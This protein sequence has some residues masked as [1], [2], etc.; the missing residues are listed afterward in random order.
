[1]KKI[2]CMLL[3]V[4]MITTLFT[5]LPVTASAA[6]AGESVARP[7]EPEMPGGEFG[8]CSWEFNILSGELTVS[9]TGSTGDFSGGAAKPWADYVNDIESVVVMNGITELGRATF[10]N[11]P[12]LKTA[13]IAPSVKTI[14][15][16]VFYK[17]KKLESVTLPDTI[18]S[19][20][21]AAFLSTGL[22]A[23]TI[24]N[25]NCTLDLYSVGFSEG[26]NMQINPKS[27]F[28]I[29]GYKGSKAYTYSLQNGFEFVDLSAEEH[30]VDVEQGT[31]YNAV[32]NQ[33][34]TTAHAG[35]R[36]YCAHDRMQS[37]KI[38]RRFY[39]YTEGVEFDESDWSF[40]MPDEDVYI[41]MECDDAWAMNLDMS[42]G[43]CLIGNQ[44]YEYLKDCIN[45]GV[46]RGQYKENTDGEYYIELPDDSYILLT[47]TGIFQFDFI[48]SP[49]YC[50]ELPNGYQRNPININFAEERINYGSLDLTVPEAGS[51]WD[52]N[53]MQ[54]EIVP[55]DDE[56]NSSERFTV[57][58][59]IWY[60]SWGISA[61][62]TFE[63]GKRY[64]VGFTLVPNEGYYFTRNTDMEIHIKGA[65]TSI[66]AKPYFMNA[67]GSV[68]FSLG[69]KW[70][71]IM[72]VGG[73]PHS[74]HIENGFVYLPG[75]RE[76]EI[77]EAVPGQSLYVRVDPYA[78][79]DDEFVVM[80]S[81]EVS[82]DDAEVLG[83][84]IVDVWEIY[85]PDNDV[86]GIL[87]YRSGEQT[88]SVLPLYQGDVR[89]PAD[90]T[91]T[92]EDYGVTG[93]LQMK[94]DKD[95]V[96]DDE[97]N[98]LYTVYDVDGNGSW[99]IK[100]SNDLV[101]SLLPTSSLTENVT[102]TTTRAENYRFSVRKIEILVKEKQKHKITINGGVAS[103]EPN[104]YA[105]EH[106]ITEAYAGDPVYVFPKA[107]FLGD[108]RYIVQTSMEASSD[109]VTVYD[110]AGVNFIM[111]DNDVTVKYT[112]EWGYQDTSIL[113]FRYDETC[114][115][116]YDGT[117]PRSESYGAQMVLRLMSQTTEGL[118]DGYRFDI[119]GD[120][121]FDIKLN[122][123]TNTYTLLS[124]HS[125]T[126][127][128]VNISLSRENSWTLPI[129]TVVIMI[130]VE[131]I[132]PKHG[133]VDYD[134]EITIQDATI[135]QL[136]LA[137]ILN[138]NN[139]PYIDPDDPD[140]FFRAD[141]NNDGRITIADVTAIQRHLAGIDLPE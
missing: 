3:S 79:E 104:D 62:D 53:T 86:N 48:Y 67:D 98:Y 102:I 134:G 93:I 21:I 51:P 89:L 35:E 11:T 60:D 61:F 124:T 106:V 46:L 103:S 5:A 91:P 32:T 139:C 114:T 20:G 99:D 107:S 40:T 120:G 36:L 17:C 39:S 133:D 38:F 140:M 22:N 42:Q 37:F 130:P 28:V 66:W 2:V 110:E 65:E 128:G 125:L 85:M 116:P 59:A 50:L 81:V 113:D 111:P 100:R 44:E 29:Y 73:E 13:G 121:N 47:P 84:E 132:T 34:V 23:I 68:Y 43:S 41:H 7:G 123:E 108:D 24:P 63:G 136:Y 4:L 118:T 58:E 97:H 27:G 25:I 16:D 83:L 52:F 33:P 78:L 69:Q 129:R 56:F 14:G 26:R 19:I 122:S 119:D 75:D 105:N 15:R 1:M 90:G 138:P 72:I 135:I 49:S 31:A 94:C 71:Q 112:Y 76:T 10:S 77:E 8:S 88:D 137:E 92:S 30:I 141:A 95:T 126:G 9:G 57:E 127:E 87:T 70:E 74:I 6:T 64:F 12:N 55:C 45:S 82:S 117:G 54:A 115:I 109:D 18:E 80:G 101:F 96:Y 131:I